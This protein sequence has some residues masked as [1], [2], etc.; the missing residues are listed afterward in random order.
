MLRP[1]EA[2]GEETVF[3]RLMTHH[4]GGR[5]TF[6]PA[7]LRFRPGVEPR[8]E[9]LTAEA[10]PLR[11]WRRD[12]VVGALGRAGFRVTEVLGAMTGAPWEPASTDLVVLAVRTGAA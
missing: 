7:T 9:V 6:T 4:E 2:E 10:V 8:L 12:E 11:G 5:L 1:G 3:L